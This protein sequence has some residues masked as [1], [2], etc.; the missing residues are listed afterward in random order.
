MSASARTRGV[1]ELHASAELLAALAR[2]R[3]CA[4]PREACG[5]LAGRRVGDDEE[6][7]VLAGSWIV[8]SFEEFANLAR[9]AERFELDPGAIVAAHE[10]ALRA[11]LELLG[12]WHS[13]GSG[14]ARPSR[15]DDRA[16]WPGHALVIVGER[17]ITAW[18]RRDDAW[19]ALAL[20]VANS[21]DA[22]RCA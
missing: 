15:A 11:G 18:E 2:A 22:R 21:T 3:V 10:R 8:E 1:A 14:V 20:T 7:G 19:S 17:E 9:S 12:F 4:L 13:H 16:T 5:V 6:R